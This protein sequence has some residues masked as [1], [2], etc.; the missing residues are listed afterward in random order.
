MIDQYSLLE[1]LARLSKPIDELRNLISTLKWDFEGTPFTLRRDHLL[2]V[3]QRYMAGELPAQSV[4]EWAN[5][6][7]GREDMTFES[8]AKDFMETIVYELANPE[9][10]ESLSP[11][12]AGEMV[13]LL[14]QN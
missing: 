14:T 9:L 8:R 2:D 7:E 12:R 10:T 5:L 6:V 3:L 13:C 1:D 11:Q 4:E